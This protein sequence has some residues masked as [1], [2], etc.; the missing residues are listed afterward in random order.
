MSTRPGQPT[1]D[2]KSGRLDRRARTQGVRYI[3]IGA[4]LDTSGAVP[5][6]IKPLIS[7]FEPSAIMPR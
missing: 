2:Q 5:V 6:V 3:D 1:A 4:I 7:L